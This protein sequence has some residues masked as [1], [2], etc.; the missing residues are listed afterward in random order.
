[1]NV[2]AV[3]A[4]AVAHDLLAIGGMAHLAGFKR[5]DHAVLLRH[6]AYPFVAF[7][8][9]A[10]APRVVAK[11]VPFYWLLF[12]CSG[13]SKALMRQALCCAQGLLQ[14]VAPVTYGLQGFWSMIA[15]HGNPLDP[16]RDRGRR[17]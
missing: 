5:L 17:D 16:S 1:M 10:A 14:T 11:I 2:V 13:S 6:A 9:H 4:G 3:A 12:I 15:R 8:A 7:D